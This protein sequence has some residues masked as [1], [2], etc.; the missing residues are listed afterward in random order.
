MTKDEKIIKPT[1][2][3]TPEKV[4]AQK[5]KEKE[6]KKQPFP[7]PKAQEKQKEAQNISH[8]EHDCSECDNAQ[9]KCEKIMMHL[10]V[11]TELA[12]QIHHHELFNILLTIVV[13]LKHLSEDE[14]SLDKIL[15][16]AKETYSDL[17]PKEM[18]VTLN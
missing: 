9:C 18:G 5:K 14:K 1:S 7:F 8:E 6:K 12:S 10:G 2:P 4:K 17:H 15:Q 3:F 13:S 11:A 16:A